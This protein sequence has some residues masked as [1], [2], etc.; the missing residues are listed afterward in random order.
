M[1]EAT[2]LEVATNL[3]QLPSRARLIRDGDLPSDVEVLLRIV[4]GEAD[5]LS[6]AMRTASLP[7][8]AVQEAA[9]FFVEQ[10]MLHPDADSYRALGVRPDA[11]TEQ[12]RRN[13]ALLLRWL[14]PDRATNSA[15]AVYAGRVT[16]AWNNLKTVER[17]TIYD[18]ARQR[19]IASRSPANVRQA[20][21]TGGPASRQESVLQRVHKPSGALARR[22][23]RAPN[24][25]TTS[26]KLWR[27]LRRLLTRS[28]A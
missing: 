9:S 12:L 22:A 21:R 28:G 23:E 11:T 15:R 6:E 27:L 24:G 25:P 10:I 8:G 18:A 5:A 1:R 13:M 7:E 2:A 4:A 3:L 14:H 16:Q 20:A 19:I 26:E 17:R